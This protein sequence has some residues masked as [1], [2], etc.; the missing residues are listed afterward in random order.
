MHVR[1]PGGMHV[2]N[3]IGV[4]GCTHVLKGYVSTGSAPDAMIGPLIDLPIT[5][6]TLRKTLLTA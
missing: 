4:I 1:M 5:L 2:R 3:S 6:L